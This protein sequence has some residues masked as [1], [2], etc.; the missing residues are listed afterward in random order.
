MTIIAE[1]GGNYKTTM[2]V[3]KPLE[4]TVFQAALLGKL[5]RINGFEPS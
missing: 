1:V 5:R 4:N 3:V 2:E